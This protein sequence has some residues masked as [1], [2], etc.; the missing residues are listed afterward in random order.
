MQ[1]AV[2]LIDRPHAA[3]ALLQPSRLEILGRLR[4]PD[5]AAGVARALGL[6]RQRVG[7]HVRELEKEGLLHHVGDRRK[8]NCVERL[9]QA[10]AR[11]YIIAPQVLGALGATPDE[12]RDRFSSSYLVSVAADA[13]RTVADL[14]ERAAQAGKQLPTL[15]IQADVRFRDA[16][17][18][19]A[20]A[21]EL[22]TCLARLV[23]EHHDPGAKSGRT[24]R[25]AV[26]GHPAPA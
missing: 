12:V 8:G 18:Q 22:A 16:A 10:T 11:H 25:F 15:T 21:E 9:V 26:L 1:D 23:R 20:F 3:A 17:A 24:F 2:S 6:P 7:Y 13:I 14:R 4:E 19:N 5:S